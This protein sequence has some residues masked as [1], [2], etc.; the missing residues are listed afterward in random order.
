[1]SLNRHSSHTGSL[2][3]LYRFRFCKQVQDA[4][5]YCWTCPMVIV[6][7]QQP[8]EQW[9]YWHLNPYYHYVAN[10][11]VYWRY[12]QY[13]QS[14][15][16]IWQLDFGIKMLW[17]FKCCWSRCTTKL[18]TYTNSLCL[19][20]SSMELEQEGGLRVWWFPLQL[21]TKDFDFSFIQVRMS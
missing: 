16:S 21:N 2:T 15:V 10:N 17:K 11:S 6:S 12:T 14:D 13:L 19:S 1:M 20:F 18:C 8:Q 5:I 4:T 9:F 7:P 3:W